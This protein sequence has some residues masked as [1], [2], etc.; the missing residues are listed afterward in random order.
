MQRISAKN[1]QLAM[2]TLIQGLQ[3]IMQPPAAGTPNRVLLVSIVDINR[4]YL[5]RLAGGDQGWVIRQA[6]ILSEP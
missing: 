3:C 1:I 4:D 5:A 6:Q 2:Q